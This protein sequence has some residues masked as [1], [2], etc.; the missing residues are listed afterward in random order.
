MQVQYLKGETTKA[1]QARREATDLREQLELYQTLDAVVK[2]SVGEVSLFNGGCALGASEI[3]RED[4]HQSVIPD[5]QYI[6]QL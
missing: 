1:E 4:L 3:R 2:G 6:D 5:L